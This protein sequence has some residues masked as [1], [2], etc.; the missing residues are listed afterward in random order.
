MTPRSKSRESSSTRNAKSIYDSPIRQLLST[1][2]YRLLSTVSPI[3]EDELAAQA[4]GINTRN[5]KLLAFALGAT[6][7]GVAGGL[8]A[9]L[10]GF[11]SP[12]SF[13]LLESIMVL[14]M[15]VLGGMGHVYGVLLGALLLSVLPEILRSTASPI[16]QA[17]FGDV[18]IDPEALRMLLF[19]LALIVVMLVRPAGLWPAP[20][21]RAM[22]DQD[23]GRD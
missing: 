11:V 23:V 1:R 15:V 6:F 14:C 22:L 12:E 18:Y 20:R 21:R 4:M 3:R 16:Q 17:V 5:I 2:S 13:G 10:Q 19:G 7:G 9:S 8:F